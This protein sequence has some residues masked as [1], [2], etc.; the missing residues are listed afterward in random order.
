MNT[1]EPRNRPR[2]V[3][4]ERVRRPT[5]AVF[6]EL[7]VRAA[8]PVVL[9]GVMDGWPA[10]ERWALDRLARDHGSRSVPAIAVDGG[11]PRFD[12]TGGVDYGEVRLADVIERI[13]E[14]PARHYVVFRVNE[15]LPQLAEDW[16]APVYTRS[17]P[18]QHSR[19][20]LAPPG[21]GGV[22]H[23]DLPENLY[24]QVVGRKHWW[25]V[26]RGA[27]RSVYPHRPWSGVP[28]YSRADVE[29]P[30]LERFPRLADVEVH[31]VVLEPGELLYIPSRWWHQARSVDTSISVNLWWA[32]GGLHLAVRA[33]ETLM[34]LRRLRL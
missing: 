25:L 13:D 24:A 22:L 34:R 32:E 10:L 18:W 15:T 30:D 21:V 3:P 16:I 19:F 6:R 4:I 12:A 9:T 20:W 8:R 33:A 14:R 5:L 28:N 26:D 7:Y 27:T 23:R 11:R 1:R 31:E 17:A 29:H 2:S